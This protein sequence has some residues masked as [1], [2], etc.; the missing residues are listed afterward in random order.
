MLAYTYPLAGLFGTMLGFFVFFVWFWLLIIDAEF[1]AQKAKLLSRRRMFAGGGSA[2]PPVPIGCRTPCAS[3]SEWRLRR[4][5]RTGGRKQPQLLD[6]VDR[7]RHSAPPA[8]IG[9]PAVL[10]GH[11]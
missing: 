7:E 11:W 10:R 4:R 5:S 2:T 1:D 8:V 6:D 3:V 9:P